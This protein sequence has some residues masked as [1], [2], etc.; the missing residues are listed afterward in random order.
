[1]KFLKFL[2]QSFACNFFLIGLEGFKFDT[3]SNI[4]KRNIT[5]LR[6]SLLC[7]MADPGFSGQGV[8]V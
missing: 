6:A 7:A 5:R 2:I 4:E 8:I 1:M 3:S